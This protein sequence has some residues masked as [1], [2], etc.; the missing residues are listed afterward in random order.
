MVVM[1]RPQ[2]VVPE[3]RIGIDDL[4]AWTRRAFPQHPRLDA[5]ERAM[6]RTQVFTRHW[7]RG[8]HQSLSATSEL[9]GGS[10]ARFNGSVDLA[11]AAAR[12]TLNDTGIAPGQVGCLVVVSSAGYALPGIASPLIGQLGLSPDVRIIQGAHSGCA[13]GV[14]GI[15][16][17][18]EQA[19]QQPG[20]PVLLVTADVWSGCQPPDADDLGSI[21]QRALFADAAAATIVTTDC[22]Q[23]PKPAIGLHTSLE[24]TV[25]DL[26]HLIT[27]WHGERGPRIHMDPGIPA[28]VDDHVVPAVVQ[29]LKT[30]ATLEQGWEPTWISTHTG[31]PRVLDALASGLGIE[32][33][34]LRHA[35][36]SLSAL[37]NVGG[38]SVL[39]VLSRHWEDPP[40]DNAHGMLLGLGPGFTV[41]AARASWI[42]P[43]PPTP[44]TVTG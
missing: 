42:N 29:W 13:G 39:D 26:A 4:C 22:A 18:A 9:D 21:I 35:R 28:A 27:V 30:T 7:I 3:N 19:R 31:G 6:R 5:A 38:A 25:L 8:L 34:L 33:R 24:R 44:P 40:A 17:A 20:I 15:I 12:K 23:V 16:R 37:G 1:S 36:A 14:W 11:V 2:V 32:R 10:L 41:V 43:T